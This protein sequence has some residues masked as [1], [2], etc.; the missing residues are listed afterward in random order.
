[1]LEAALINSFTLSFASSSSTKEASLRSVSSMDKGAA[2]ISEHEMLQFIVENV[3]RILSKSF[4]LVEFDELEGVTLLSLL[5]GIFETLTPTAAVNFNAEPHESCVEKLETFLIKTLGYKVPPMMQQAFPQAFSRAEKTVMYPVMYWVLKRMPENE[6]RVYLSRY[7]AKIEIP[8]DLLMQDDGLRESYQI[9]DSLR[10]EFITVHKRVDALRE[11]H[12]DPLEARR[13]LKNLEDE[14]EKLSGYIAAAQKKLSAVPNKDALVSACHSLNQEKEEN[15]KY[16]EK[17]QEQ[18]HALHTAQRRNTELGSRLKNVRRDL[19]EGRLDA[20]IQRYND[21]TSTNRMKLDE[22]LPQELAEKRD[23]NAALSKVAT[24]PVDIPTLEAEIAQ[25]DSEL[26][27]LTKQVQ[28]RQRPGDDG[29]SIVQMKQQVQRVTNKKNSSLAEL[30]QIH[31]EMQRIMEE[32]QEKERNI[33]AFRNS[34]VLKGEDFKK[35]SMQ[36]TSKTAAVKQMRK[37]LDDLRGEFGVLQYTE[38]LLRDRH[39]TLLRDLNAMEGRMGARGFVQTAETLSRVSE[40]KN[41]VEIAK[42]QT[43]EELSQVVQEFVTKIR[44]K[45]NKLA[46]E[47]LRLRS[48]RTQAAEIEQEY[49]DKKQTYEYQEQMMMQEVNKLE[50]EVQS[51]VDETKMNE[52]LFHRLQVQLQL[53]S[54]Q[55][56]RASDERSFQAGSSQYDP[57]ENIK[58]LSQCLL[59]KTE[60]LEKRVKD[61]Q[62]KRRDIEENHENALQQVEWF[63]GL[64]KLMEAKVASIRTD[65][66]SGAKG[67]RQNLDGEIASIMGTAGRSGVDMLVLGNN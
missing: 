17:Y 58:T 6:K 8:E 59:Q 12:A 63:T 23:Q 67:G 1:M 56:K 36:V 14:R 32:I 61:L 43:L 22:A 19:Q 55:E 33:D 51:L 9:Y 26:G 37:R 65:A 44:D 18:Q 20:A 11:A 57:K 25:L 16:R 30:Q 39:E 35:Y 66:A 27:V 3:N 38:Q 24:D 54:A 40:K 29:N 42:G 49:E 21:E 64:R 46:P 5:S 13:K 47:I 2:P 15:R 28:E 48:T 62:K 34:N 31:S 10:S 4:S 52:A 7:L 45:R 53:L 50:M 60:S 41:E